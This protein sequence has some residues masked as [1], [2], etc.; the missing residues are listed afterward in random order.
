MPEIKVPRGLGADVRVIERGGDHRIGTIISAAGNKMWN[1]RFDSCTDLEIRSS[2]QLKLHKA[3]YGKPTQSLAGNVMASVKSMHPAQA[4]SRQIIMNR[5]QT[6]SCLRAAARL[7]STT[8]ALMKATLLKSLN[9]QGVCLQILMKASLLKSLN[10]PDAC[11]LEDS[12][13]IFRF[14]LPGYLPLQNL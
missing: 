2:S 11:L 5:L 3:A 14:H 9:N 13:F 6:A 12:R 1:V 4:G 7:Q 10:D 8:E